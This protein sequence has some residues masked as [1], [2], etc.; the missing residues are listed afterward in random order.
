MVSNYQ[1]KNQLA[2]LNTTSQIFLKLMSSTILID[3][4]GLFIYLFI[5]GPSLG[6]VWHEPGF[7]KVPAGIPDYFKMEVIW[8]NKISF[9]HSVQLFIPGVGG[10]GVG[11]R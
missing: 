9:L 4:H 8:G 10:P 6:K 3:L 5:F 2:F 11:V 7:S 1:N